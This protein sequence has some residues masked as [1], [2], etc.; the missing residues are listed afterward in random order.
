MILT[1][2]TI[3]VLGTTFLAAVLLLGRFTLLVGG[4]FALF[5][6]TLS[7]GNDLIGPWQQVGIL[8]FALAMSVAG[9]PSAMRRG[10][11]ARLRRRIRARRSRA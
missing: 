11:R 3:A 10:D 8:G 7:Y 2:A 9:R 6:V 5:S 1:G 4:F